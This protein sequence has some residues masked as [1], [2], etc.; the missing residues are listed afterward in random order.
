MP[1]AAYA[2]VEDVPASWDTY[3]ER[4]KTLAGSRPEG[5]LVHLAGPTDEGFRIIELWES[6]AASERFRNDRS[7]GEV[8][9]S[10]P[11]QQLQTTFRDLIVTNL[12]RMPTVE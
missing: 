1:E 2:L 10:A 7:I 12:L 9:R 11:I 5:L 3:L 4:I 6:K 8:D